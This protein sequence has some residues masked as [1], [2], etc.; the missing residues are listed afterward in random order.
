MSDLPFMTIPQAAAK[1]N[2]HPETV[3]RIAEQMGLLTRKI[4]QSWVL[5][6]DDLNTL[7][8]RESLKVVRSRKTI[9]RR[10]GRR[11]SVPLLTRI[12]PLDEGYTTETTTNG[13][14]IHLRL[15]NVQPVPLDQVLKR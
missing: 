8:G 2:L 9:K 10:T 1:L 7:R 11:S 15:K 5:T 12:V 14:G 6:Q 4:G 13:K 3:R